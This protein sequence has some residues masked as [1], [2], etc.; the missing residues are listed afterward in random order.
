[1]S[2]KPLPPWAETWIARII[3]WVLRLLSFVPRK[4]LSQVAV[5]LGNLWRLLDRRHVAIARENLALAY[6]L[7]E[8][9]PFVEA[10]LRKVFVHLATVALEF[11]SLYR[12]SRDNLDEYATFEGLENAR[13][14]FSHGKGILFLTAHYG[15]WELMA[16]AASLKLAAPMHV[17]ARP[18]D[19][20][21]LDR[22]LTGLRSRTGN[23]VLDKD[24][25][26][27]LVSLILKEN[28]MVGILLDQNSSW[29]EGVYVPFFDRIA[30]TNKGLA[31]FALRS[32]SP[33]VPVFSTRQADGRHRVVIQSPI[34]M[35]R[36]GDVHADVHNQ[37]QKLNNIIEAQIRKVP[38]QWLWVHR[39]WRIKG[40][41]DRAVRK[42][43]ISPEVV[44][45]AEKKENP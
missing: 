10:T 17:M 31:L 36:T 8:N 16:L 19:F 15:N 22:V 24:K 14:A 40:I 1:M 42:M 44:E 34:F 35:E 27:G 11:P 45:L 30:C 43:K 4:W 28:G 33:I 21:P 9:D 3:G 20:T 13:E 29:F 2:E 7:P 25:S 39:R 38:E 26:A 6:K 41:P 5:S 23:V 18:L 12:I 37:T 32:G